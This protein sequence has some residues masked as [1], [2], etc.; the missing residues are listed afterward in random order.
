MSVKQPQFHNNVKF[1]ILS[2][3]AL[4]NPMKCCHVSPV[5]DQTKTV[6]RTAVRV[7]GYPALMYVFSIL[8]VAAGA[9]LRV[10]AS[11]VTLI[12]TVLTLVAATAA[13]VLT[14][15]EVVILEELV[16]VVR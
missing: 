3:V 10:L 6:V 9:V 2:Q 4:V 13:D 15:I 5:K 12:A 11:S 8:S 1:L 7:A 14:K 16:E